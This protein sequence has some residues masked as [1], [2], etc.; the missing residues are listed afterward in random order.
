MA[1]L[2]QELK[3]KNQNLEKELKSKGAS[4]DELERGK[5]DNISYFKQYSIFSLH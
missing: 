3:N 1:D 4:V 5:Y 2:I